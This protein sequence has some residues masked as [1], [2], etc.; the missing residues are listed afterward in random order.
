VI[1]GTTFTLAQVQAFDGSQTVSTGE[2]T[3]T[4][5]GYTGDSFGGT[6]DY[7]YTLDATIDND[8][9]SATGNDAVTL[10]HFDDSLAIQVNGVG[11]TT[12]SDNLVIR[13]IDDVP[14]FTNIADSNNDGIVELSAPN[15]SATYS[16]QFA[17]WNYG[18]DGPSDNLNFDIGVTVGNAIV[19]TSSS[20]QVVIDLKDPDGNSAGVLTLNANGDDSLVVSAR[21]PDLTTDKLLTGDVTVGGPSLTKTINSSIS[22]LEVTVTASD[23]DSTLGESKDDEVNPSN[24]GWGVSDNQVDPGESLTFSFSNSVDTFEFKTTGFTGGNQANNVASLAITVN[25]DDGSFGTLTTSSIS[26]QLTAV[27]ELA[28]F[29]SGKGINSVTVESNEPSGG[30]GFRL[31]D[32][33]VGQFVSHDPDSLDYSFTL[34]SL[35]VQD[36]DGDTAEQ[37]FSVHLDGS[38]TGSFSVSPIALDLDGDGA[39]YLSR[40]AGV[41]F[42]DENSGESVSTAWV[43]ADDGLL[44]IDANN[45]GTVDESREYVFTEWSDTAETDMEA[46]RE[47][48]DT[49]NNGMLDA[50]DEAWS[51]FAVWQDANSDGKTDE[52]ELSSLY[53]LGVESIA[54]D[55]AAVSESR[56]DAD[57]DVLVHGQSQV[58]WMDGSVTLAEDTSFAISAGEV[59]LED[60]EALFQED[61][62]DSHTTPETSFSTVQ[63]DVPVNGTQP[64]ED[65]DT[66]TNSIE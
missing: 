8:S 66:S 4:L 58:N 60:E 6:I 12:A 36:G 34:G 39:E 29:D 50:G 23:G 28:G 59:L 31:N 19:T 44:V 16:Q 35:A 37:A 17:D 21:D 51:Q 52:G 54:L 13:A 56:T 26:G 20:S 61:G 18:A 3:L 53:Q 2:G 11:G 62:S 47:V 15:V 40:D 55:Y 5:D 9:K 7:T 45:S 14:E 10:D 64:F 46:V 65:L 48:F 30:D 27:H 33:T 32:V 63:V 24:Q 49:N 22:D 38:A 41:V 42:T 1:G 57:G 43:G 25:Y